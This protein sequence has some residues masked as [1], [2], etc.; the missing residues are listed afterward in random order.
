[1]AETS[2]LKTVAFTILTSAG[3][4]ATY[5]FMGIDSSGR[6]IAEDT[7]EPKTELPTTD[8]AI[9]LK[10]LEL[11][12]K[13]LA[14]KMKE[15]E[16]QQAQKN[17]YEPSTEVSYSLSGNWLGS[18]GLRYQI[19][20]TNSQVSYTEEGNFLGQ[21]FTSSSGTGILRGN[22]IQLSGFGLY[23]QNIQLQAQ[24]INNHQLTLTGIDLNGN[25]LE[26]V[27]YKQ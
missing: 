10:E 19:N 9:K 8:P 23:G 11:K 6:K 22:N 24:V 2:N 13:E 26:I 18:N 16:L 1:M 20:Q 5:H 15:L 21:K 25:P 12:E 27:L 4:A 17:K 3:L 14:L 7:K